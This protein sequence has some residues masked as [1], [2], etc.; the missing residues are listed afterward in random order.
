M[1]MWELA[2]EEYGEQCVD[3][4]CILVKRNVRNKRVTLYFIE[5]VGESFMRHIGV[6]NIENEP[7]ITYNSHN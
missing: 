5:R 6:Y 3:R 2:T 4:E 7:Y 1:S